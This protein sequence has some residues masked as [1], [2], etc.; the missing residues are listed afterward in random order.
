MAGLEARKLARRHTSPELE[1]LARRTLEA[2]P[3]SKSA[4]QEEEAQRRE[5]AHASRQMRPLLEAIEKASAGRPFGYERYK[6]GFDYRLKE[7]MTT[8]AVLCSYE[9]LQPITSRKDG[10]K[11]GRPPRKTADAL[12]ELVLVCDAELRDRLRRKP[13]W[14]DV[15]NEMI[16]R[17]GADHVDANLTVNGKKI[18]SWRRTAAERSPQNVLRHVSFDAA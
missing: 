2:N 6:D 10:S 14:R 4:G 8:V 9:R 16:S 17:V 15:W 3:C 18:V 5:L 11:A 1:A 13:T 12:D 7:A